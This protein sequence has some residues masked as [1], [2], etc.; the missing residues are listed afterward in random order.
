LAW[1]SDS[2]PVARLR[3]LALQ[4]PSASQSAFEKAEILVDD[5]GNLAA[6]FEPIRLVLPQPDGSWQPADPGDPGAVLAHCL[7]CGNPWG[8]VIDIVAWAWDR[9][10]RWWRR[11]RLVDRLVDP[12]WLS[13]DKPVRLVGTPAEWLADRCEAACILDWSIDIAAVFFGCRLVPTS[14][15][16]S[17]KLLASLAKWPAVAVDRP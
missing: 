15:A 7:P 5:F 11:T 8:E 10:G 13:G 17:N 12:E 9:P 3:R 1:R 14:L 4:L 6:S 2:N 16:L